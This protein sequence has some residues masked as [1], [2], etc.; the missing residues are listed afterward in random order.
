[1]GLFSFYYGSLHFLTYVLF[2]RGGDLT[3]VPADVIKRPF[4]AIGMICFA[5]MIPLAVTSTNKMIQRLGGKRWKQLHKLTYVIAVGAVIHFWMIVKSD[6]TYPAF[7]AVI[8][9]VLL[10]YRWKKAYFSSK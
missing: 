2:D 5:M 4:I 8:V 9:A 7:F 10:S 6:I 1:M 3:T